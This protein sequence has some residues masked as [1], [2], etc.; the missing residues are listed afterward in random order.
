MMIV[1]KCKKFK[2]PRVTHVEQHLLQKMG[3]HCVHHVLQIKAI[4]NIVAA[5]DVANR[6]EAHTSELQSLMRISY[7]VFCM[8]K[9]K[10]ILT[11]A[12]VSLDDKTNKI[13][14]KLR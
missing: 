7:A 10:T 1:V 4:I 13:K 5:V 6:S 2:K 12:P 8:K 14:T 3:R 11:D 9:K